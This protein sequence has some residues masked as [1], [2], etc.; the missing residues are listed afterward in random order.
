MEIKVKGRFLRISPTKAKLISQIIKNLKVDLA[1]A[2]LKFL[3]QKAAKMILKLL[4]SAKAQA[5]EKDAEM[6]KLFVKEI[7][8]DFGPAFKRR[9]IKSRGRADLISKRTSH[10]ALIL[11]DEQTKSESEETSKKSAQKAEVSDGS[12]D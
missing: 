10:I 9:L 6:E 12:K 2:R 11:S 7:R 1:E 4:N 5:K 8:V 3:P